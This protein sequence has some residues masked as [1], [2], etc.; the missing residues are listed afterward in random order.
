MTKR[1]ATISST[2]PSVD[3]LPNRDHRNGQTSAENT[4]ASA[5]VTGVGVSF[6]RGLLLDRVARWLF[7]WGLTFEVRGGLRLAAR[8]PLDRGVSPLRFHGAAHG[9]SLP[10]QA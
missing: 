4:P 1:V 10:L 7:W 8:R 6:I 2:L 3:A 5:A 9:W